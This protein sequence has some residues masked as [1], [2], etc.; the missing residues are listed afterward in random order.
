MNMRIFTLDEVVEILGLGENH[1]I[2]LFA[3]RDII[4]YVMPTDA[5]SVIRIPREGLVF[6][7]DSS[8]I[9]HTGLE[10][11]EAANPPAED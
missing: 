5:G 8:T 2:T 7:L 10:E 1:V 9:P 4:G 3:Q 11:W 6:F